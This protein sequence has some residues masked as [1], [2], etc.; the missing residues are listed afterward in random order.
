VWERDRTAELARLP[1]ANHFCA[2]SHICHQAAD[3]DLAIL[4]LSAVWQIPGLE[5]EQ[6]PRIDVALTCDL[7]IREAELVVTSDCEDAI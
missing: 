4:R 3:V 6:D 1:A 7:L 2:D 5:A